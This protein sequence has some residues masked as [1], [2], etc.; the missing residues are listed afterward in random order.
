MNGFNHTNMVSFIAEGNFLP[1]KTDWGDK[2][3]V[4][5]RRFQVGG[6]EAEQFCLLRNQLDMVLG[7][8]FDG[9][10]KKVLQLENEVANQTGIICLANGGY[11]DTIHGNSMHEELS[12]GKLFVVCQFILQITQAPTLLVPKFV[13]YR[14]H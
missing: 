4:E 8:I 3:P 9:E 10:V 6:R 2:F 11:T 5:Y 1:T 7:T 14:A 12:S 13:K